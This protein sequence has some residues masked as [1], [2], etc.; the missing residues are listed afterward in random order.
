MA[1]R[2]VTAGPELLKGKSGGFGNGLG[3]AAGS[4]ATI[5][6]VRDADMADTKAFG[7]DGLVG[8]GFDERGVDIGGVHF[9]WPVEHS[10]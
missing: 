8:A 6:D 1:A 4:G 10:F 2:Q 3:Y 9:F 5:N 7:D